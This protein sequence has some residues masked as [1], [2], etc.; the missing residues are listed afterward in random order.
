EAGLDRVFVVG[1]RELDVGTRGERAFRGVVGGRAFGLGRRGTAGEQGER[2]KRGDDKC[3]THGTVPLNFCAFAC[4]TPRP[5]GSRAAHGGNRPFLFG[6]A[7]TPAGRS[8]RH[9]SARRTARAACGFGTRN[10]AMLPPRPTC[11]VTASSCNAANISSSERSSP[12]ATTA[13]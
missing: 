5:L 4:L 9:R 1:A 11:T 10:F 3:G 12:I 8:N 7:K 2:E 13:A 6:K